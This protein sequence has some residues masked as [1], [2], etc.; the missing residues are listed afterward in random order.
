MINA[1]IIVGYLIAIILLGLY[2][3]RYVKTDSDFFLAGRS[4]NKWVIAATIIATDVAAIYI[5]GPAGVAYKSGVPILLIG[6]TGNM[7][8]ALSA[9]FFVPRLRRLKITTISEILEERYN[10]WIRV[11]VTV[12]WVFYYALFAGN[13]MYVF[14]VV[15]API[16][17]IDPDTVIVCV[18]GAV[19]L[20][21]FFSGLL[22]VAYTDVIQVLLILVGGAIMLPLCLKAVGGVEEFIQKTPPDYFL[23][24]RMDDTYPN[25]K[26]LIM[27]VLLGLP[28]WCTS[29]YM[30]QRCMAG[31]TI[32]DASRGLML[33][34]LFTGSITLAYI[35][36]GIC[37]TILYTADQLPQP[38]AVL[39]QMFQDVLPVGL[40][41]IFIAALLGATTS[42]SSALLNSLS[43]L[44][45]NDVYHRFRPGRTPQHYLW[46]GRL[47][48]AGG[49]AAGL[50]FAFNVDR[51]GGIIEANLE[52]M[53]FFEPPIFVIV[54][55]CL[56][57]R[58]ANSWGAALAGVGGVAFNA[59][60][61]QQGMSAEDRSFIVFPL[62]IV[63]ITLGSM[64]GRMI[65]PLSEADVARTNQ[66]FERMRGEPV[67]WG[68]L[69]GTLG[70]VIAAASLVVMIL[71]MVFVDLVPRPANVLVIMGLVATWVAGLYMAIPMFVSNDSAEASESAVEHSWIHRIIGSGWCW[72]SAYIVVVLCMLGLYFL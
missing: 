36:P 52:I 33:A 18:G 71:C 29:Q 5:V 66:F 28:Y 17:Q 44:A 55:A 58:G 4:L 24:W 11:L 60:A 34:A 65:R 26:T 45:I 62:C 22:A 8:A 46:M 12:I 23:F 14:A 35:L 69:Q 47:V 54:A 61:A 68:D 63:A 7:I 40:G 2:L 51:L 15:L 50:L 27:F 13:S 9:L 25:Y 57:W 64:V 70:L 16:L 39:V 32:R 53:S 56:L 72:V 3:S 37:G 31:H 1:T 10:V 67:R 19:I 21:C 49:G 42:H 41:G 43:T 30:L 59:I 6:W 48:T 38:D 20:Y